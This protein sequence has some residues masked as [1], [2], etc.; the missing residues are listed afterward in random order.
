MIKATSWAPSQFLI[1]PF[2]IHDK[3]DVTYDE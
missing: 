2:K 1:I 3:P